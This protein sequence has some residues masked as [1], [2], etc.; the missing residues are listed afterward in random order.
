MKTMQT[1]LRF[2]VLVAGIALALTGAVPLL[3][4]WADDGP[5]VSIS[6][7]NAAPREV[8]ETTQAA[9]KREYAN[10]WK[11]MTASLRENR[12]D[13]LGASFVGA[14]KEQIERQV[15]QQKQTHL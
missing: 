9:I 1:T 3:S 6:V 2:I 12:S 13:Q 4:A 5:Q 11:A 14:A 8:E 7:A 10:A 15:E